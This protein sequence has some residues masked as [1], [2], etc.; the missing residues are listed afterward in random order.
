MLKGLRNIFSIQSHDK[1]VDLVPVNW[2][3][4]KQASDWRGVVRTVRLISKHK[5]VRVPNLSLH[6]QH[7]FF[8]TFRDFHPILDI[9]RLY[10]INK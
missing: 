4:S 5:G 2:R 7:N 6:G 3:A 1:G 10:K 9:I 8:L